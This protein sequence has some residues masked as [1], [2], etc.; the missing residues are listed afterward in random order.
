MRLA[1]AHSARCARTPWLSAPSR[2]ASNEADTQGGVRLPAS[3]L[4]LFR[5][6][7][8]R[9]EGAQPPGDRNAAAA[10]FLAAMGRAVSA[11]ARLEVLESNQRLTWQ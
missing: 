11:W 2:V 4:L 3:F 8:L 6:D 5:A 1:Q 9:L 7:R 10:K